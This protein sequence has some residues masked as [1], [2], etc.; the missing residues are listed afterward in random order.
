MDDKKNRHEIIGQLEDLLVGRDSYLDPF[1]KFLPD[2]L[3]NPSLNSID[4]AH[5]VKF[6]ELALKYDKTPL[7]RDALKILNKLVDPQDGSLNI[8]GPD[9]F[10]ENHNFFWTE[11]GEHTS[12]TEVI[13]HI[14]NKT[15]F[16]SSLG[17]E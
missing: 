17:E 14:F 3:E 11:L 15:I 16:R 12:A 2:M 4:P 13:L 6:A 9:I 5:A 8:P 7:I 1:L 10:Y